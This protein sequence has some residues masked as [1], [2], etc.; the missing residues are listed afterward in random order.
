MKINFLTS[1]FCMPNTRSL[2]YPFVCYEKYFYSNNL[3]WKFYNKI[4]DSIYDCDCLIIES[5]YHG[6]R[7]RGEKDIILNETSKL[8]DKI[9]VLHYFDMSD[10][11]ALLHPEI[12]PYVSG[13]YKAQIL[14]DLNEYM[15]PHYGNRIYTDFVNANYGVVDKKPSVSS[16]V[17]NS[18][19]TN[20]IR[21]SWNSGFSNYSYT[22]KYLNEL[23]RKLNIK[24]LLRYPV[25]FYSPYLHRNNDISCRINTRYERDTV[26]WFRK[27]TKQILADKIKTNRIKPIEY[28]QELKKS[29]ITISP[30]AWGEIN[31]KDYES[32]IYGALLIKPDM[33]HLNTWPNYYISGETYLSYKWDCSDLLDVVEDALLNYKKHRE[34]AV[35]AQEK[36]RSMLLSNDAINEF[37]ERLKTIVLNE[38]N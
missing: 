30:F 18:E 17:K 26:A 19:D 5:N 33:S 29:K 23:Y 21:L 31:Y 35:T 37:V 11:T 38:S 14:K 22:G 16:I 25:K 20:K 1:G 24:Y 3:A 7:W 9:K 36:Y 32:F 8:K 10:S 4:D 15:K 6:K 13:Y 28:Y 2:Y 27:E 12:L 34:I